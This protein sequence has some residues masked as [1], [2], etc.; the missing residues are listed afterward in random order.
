[1]LPTGLIAVGLVLAFTYTF[2]YWE[3]LHNANEL[4]RVLL[5]EEIVDRGTFRLDARWGELQAGSTFD[6]SVTPEGHKYSN[7]A[8][9][10]SLLGVPAYLALKGLHVVVG[11]KPSLAEVTWA[12]RFLTSILP[13]LLFLPLF[14]RAADRFAGPAGADGALVAFALGSMAFPYAHVLFSHALSAACA[15]GA[16]ALALALAHGEPR[17]PALAALAVGFLLGWAVLADYQS[18]LVLL[19]VVAYLAVKSPTRLRDLA[20]VTVGGA[21]PAALFALYHWACFGAPWKTGYSFAPDPAHKEGLLGVIGPNR[22]ALAQALVTPDNGLLV[23]CPWVVLAAFGLVVVWRRAQRAEA[24]ALAALALGYVLFV[25]SLVPEFG[26]AGWSVGPRY[27]VVA[28]PFFAWLAAAA[29]DA[30]DQRPLLRTLAH[31][32]VVAS[33]VIMV[34]AT[35][36]F[37]YWPTS[38]RN[39]LY[40]VAFWALGTGHVPHSLGTAVGL[41]GVRALVPLYAVLAAL[42]VT[43]LGRGERGRSAGLL[44]A[45]ALAA[46]WVAAIGLAPRTADAAVRTHYLDQIWEPPP[47]PAAPTE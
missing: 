39:P 32:L 4:P 10:T 30:V 2:P 38:L 43:L 34:A 40:E 29:L 11:G 23:L 36:T 3:R 22:A 6:V 17:R 44:G 21:P 47:R 46:A 37:P 28:M 26:R 9:G 19:V 16:F 14:R 31:G 27:I 15:G 41:H 45:A 33:V 13:F 7:K 1:V 24:M 5:T 20:L 35:T 42:V 25:G 18:A 12:C 8:P